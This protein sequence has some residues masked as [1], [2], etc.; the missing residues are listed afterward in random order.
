MPMEQ[1]VTIYRFNVKTSKSLGFFLLA[2]LSEPLPKSCPGFATL[3]SKLLVGVNNQFESIDAMSI[4]ET[5]RTNDW[6]I[7]YS[8]PLDLFICLA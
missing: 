2:S 7:S 4:D 6:W 1:Y 8:P 3:V 5:Y